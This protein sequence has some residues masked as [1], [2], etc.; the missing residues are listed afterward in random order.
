MDSYTEAEHISPFQSRRVTEDHDIGL[1]VRA[2]GSSASYTVEVDAGGEITFKKGALGAEAVDANVGT[3]G[4]IDT[5]LSAYDSFGELVAYLNALDDY[6]AYLGDVLPADSSDDTLLLTAAVQIKTDAG[7]GICK[8]TS[9]ALNV[10]IAVDGEDFQYH[11]VGCKNELEG[12]VVKPTGTGADTVKLYEGTSL[13]YQ[14]AGP[15]T[16]VEA[17]KNADEFKHGATGKRLLLRLDM[18]S[19]LTAAELSTGKRTVRLSPMRKRP[20]A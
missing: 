18:A 3:A 17:S 16:G 8:D 15:T 10:S 20:A 1:Y 2:V 9:V 14:V 7:V 5:N 13:E 19:S 4:V 12:Y 6:E 11:G